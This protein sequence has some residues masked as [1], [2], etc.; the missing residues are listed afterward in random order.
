MDPHT[1]YTYTVTFEA[2]PA[3][4]ATPTWSPAI[5]PVVWVPWS[6]LSEGSASLSKKS[7]PATI[8]ACP[9]SAWSSWTPVSMLA[10]DTAPPPA[11]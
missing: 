8:V 6:S 11:A 2:A 5:V 4:P 1:R 3:T 10:I 7:Q 9:N